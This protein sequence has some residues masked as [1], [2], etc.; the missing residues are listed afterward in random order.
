MS[1]DSERLQK[2]VLRLYL[3]QDGKCFWCAG[4]MSRFN[5][6]LMKGK[7]V[8]KLLPKNLATLD[9]RVNRLSK[10]RSFDTRTVAACLVCNNARG[11]FDHLMHARG[12]DVG[13][14]WDF[15]RADSLED[16]HR[17]STPNHAGSNP[18]RRTKV[19][20]KWK[21]SEKIETC[22]NIKSEMRS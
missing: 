12:Y 10:A 2:R 16:R 4:Q 11:A 7:K 15:S 19:T 17:N 9:H 13:D 18:A 21:R 6:D 3:A 14:I 22:F 8:H 5:P 1:G 20:V